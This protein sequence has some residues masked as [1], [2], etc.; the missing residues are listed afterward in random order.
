MPNQET[1]KSFERER[2]RQFSYR[3]QT[4]P[5]GSDGEVD[6]KLKRKKQVAPEKAVKKQK[7]GETSRSLSFPSTIRATEQ[8][9]RFSGCQQGVLLSLVCQLG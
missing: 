9:C 8:F 7:T 6:K 4:K 1:V 3:N 2:R 5:N